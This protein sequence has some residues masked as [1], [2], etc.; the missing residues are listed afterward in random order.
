MGDFAAH[1]EDVALFLTAGVVED[2]IV[3]E[4][5]SPIIIYQML[6]GRRLER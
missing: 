5:V 1:G 3:S 4:F 2:K 6:G